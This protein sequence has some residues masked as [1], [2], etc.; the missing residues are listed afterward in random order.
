MRIAEIAPP[1]FQ[2]PPQGYGGIELVASLVTDG[3]AAR[4]HEVTLFAARGSQTA[5]QLVTPL[6]ETPDPALLGSTYFEASH[7]LAAYRYLTE[8]GDFDIIHDHSGIVGPALG[9][10]A[11]P[12]PVVHTLHGPWTVPARRFYST[13][14]DAVHLVAVSRSQ[15]DDNPDVMYAGIVPNGI[16]LD[17]YPYRDDKEP[18]LIY[19]GRS[20]PDKG[21]LQAIEVA[22]RA[23]VPLVMIVKRNEPFERAFWDEMVA[24]M[25]N[26]TVTV[27]DQVDHDTKVDL[28]ARAMAMVFPIHWPEPFGLVIIEAMACGTPVLTRPLGAAPELVVDGVTGFL[29]ESIDDLAQAVSD[30]THLAPRDCRARVAE[31]FSAAS[32]VMGYE[33]LFETVVGRVDGKRLHH[34]QPS[35]YS[36]S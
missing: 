16:D 12:A 24:P 30:A 35:R 8:R 18:F 33:Q 1:W 19:I 9:A 6:D 26:D 27:Y 28:L 2:V 13:I 5:A 17:A 23:E 11:P 10:L 3:L 14:C 4:G 15:H 36:G 22:R 31:H 25:L 34:S 21:P 20:N 29:R 32:M 7:A